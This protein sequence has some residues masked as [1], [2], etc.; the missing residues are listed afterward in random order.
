MARAG[1]SRV[2][3]EAMA[4]A[5]GLFLAACAEQEATVQEV[6]F[7]EVRRALIGRHNAGKPDARALL[8]SLSLTPPV[9]RRKGT[10]WDRVDAT[11]MALYGLFL[12]RIRQNDNRDKKEL[13]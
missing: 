10:D 13:R 11:M 4:M 3:V 2:S 12:E 9:T 5:R 7:Q 8:E 1:S 6:E